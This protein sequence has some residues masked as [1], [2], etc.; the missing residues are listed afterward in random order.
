MGINVEEFKWEHTRIH[1]LT[2][3]VLMREQD[4]RGLGDVKKTRERELHSWGCG[5]LKH[6]A[7]GSQSSQIKGFQ[8][9]ALF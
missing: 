6:I 2:Y 9:N 8:D 3:I 1:L 5:M 7:S 4:K